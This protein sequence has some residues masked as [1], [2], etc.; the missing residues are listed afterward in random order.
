MTLGAQRA[1]SPVTFPVV[2]YPGGNK[3][4]AF[5]GFLISGSLCPWA[6]GSQLCCGLTPCSVRL[7]LPSQQASTWLLCAVGSGLHL[8]TGKTI[9]R[10]SALQQLVAQPVR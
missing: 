2:F 8:C 7:R 4:L 9:R 3:Y 5:L 10:V 6:L 1:E